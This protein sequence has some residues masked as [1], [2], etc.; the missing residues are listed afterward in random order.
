MIAITNRLG[1]QGLRPLVTCF[2]MS[3]LTPRPT[4]TIYEIVAATDKD[5]MG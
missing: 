2:S 4:K 5:Y 1:P 3:R